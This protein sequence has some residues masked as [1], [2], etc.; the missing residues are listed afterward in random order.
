MTLMTKMPYLN[1]LL[2]LSAICYHSKCHTGRTCV[3]DPVTEDNWKVDIRT[4]RLFDTIEGVI[5]VKEVPV[6]KSE[7]DC[8]D[9]EM[10]EFL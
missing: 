7:V 4:H 10:W 1:I 3:Y 9:C 2:L 6:C 5:K 8:V